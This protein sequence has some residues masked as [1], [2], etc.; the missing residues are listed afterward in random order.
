MEQQDLMSTMKWKELAEVEA[1]I[2]LH[3]GTITSVSEMKNFL[4]IAFMAFFLNGFSQQNP[5]IDPVA[6][7]FVLPKE[8]L[9]ALPS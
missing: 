2:V 4:L 1:Y 8:N 6:V 9:Y 3:D 7:P 5:T